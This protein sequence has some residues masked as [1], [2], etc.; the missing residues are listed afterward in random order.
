MRLSRPPMGRTVPTG[1]R[2]PAAK[3]W[4]GPGSARQARSNPSGSDTAARSGAS[5]VRMARVIDSVPPSPGTPRYFT[6]PRSPPSLGSRVAPNPS[7]S[8]YQRDRYISPLSRVVS[9]MSTPTAPSHVLTNPRRP[10]AATTMS[11]DTVVPSSRTTP[12]TRGAPRAAT[13]GPSPAATVNPET[14]SPLTT[15]TPGSASAAWRST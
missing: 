15:V 8:R 13:A 9:G 5:S 6:Y 3:N 1:S 14:P 10:V 4:S 11:A 7:G 2:G 12:S